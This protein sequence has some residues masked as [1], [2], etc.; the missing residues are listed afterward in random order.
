LLPLI[1]VSA[2]KTHKG[3]SQ[4]GNGALRNLSGRGGEGKKRNLSP[5]YYCLFMRFYFQSSAA[6][7]WRFEPARS[8]FIWCF[9]V[10]QGLFNTFFFL[11]IIFFKDE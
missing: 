7:S 6:T 1:P 9:W 5:T 11:S 10:T 2:S 8:Q 4:F 3:E